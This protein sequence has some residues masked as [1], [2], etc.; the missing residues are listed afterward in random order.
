VLRRRRLCQHTHLLPVVMGDGLC[1]DPATF[2]VGGREASDEQG[3][4]EGSEIV[5]RHER[6]IGNVDIGTRLHPI[7]RQELG[8]L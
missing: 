1:N 7:V 3:V 8:D 2:T 6:C 5:L 4:P